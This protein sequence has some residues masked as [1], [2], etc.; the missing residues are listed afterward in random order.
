LSLALTGVLSLV[1]SLA[2]TG[3]LSLVLSLTGT[4]ILALALISVSI[5]SLVLSLTGTSILA[6]ALIGASILSL[7]GVLS[8]ALAGVL[9]LALT[10]I[11]TL[12]VTGTAALS[13]AESDAVILSTT[14]S[15]RH[16][17]RLMVGSRSHCASTVEASSQTFSESSREF[18]VAVAVVIDTL[19]ESEGLGV[20]GLLWVVILANILNSEMRVADD[21]AAIESLGSSVIGVVGVGEGTGLQIRDTDCEID[22]CA[23]GDVFSVGRADNHGRDHLA[24]GGNITH[25]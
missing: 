8:L 22:G 3:V 6:L 17:H 16:E 1:L 11:L 5:L 12:A 21:L 23:L 18:S 14:L 25:G 24:G 7:T 15:D 19:E 9:S 4:S 10:L 13:N 20:E 2:L